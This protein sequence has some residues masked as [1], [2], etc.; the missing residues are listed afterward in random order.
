MKIKLIC[1]GAVKDAAVN[2]CIAKYA[3]RIPF[4][5]PFEI[6]NLPDVMTG[7]S[8]DASKQKELEGDKLLAEISNGDYLLLLDE[9]GK[10]YTSRQFADYL[11]KRGIEGTRNLIMAVGGPYGFCKRVYDRADGMLS[12]SAMTFPH[13]IVRLFLVEQIYRAG[14][15]LRGE[16]YHHD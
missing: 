11:D 2:E 1:I 12:L 10:N 3:K 7:K 14:T 5:W 15:I 16:P 4:Y 8:V 9:R 13:E 6:V